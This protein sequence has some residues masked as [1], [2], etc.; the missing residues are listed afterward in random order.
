MAQEIY[1]VLVLF[2][3]HTGLSQINFQYLGQANGLSNVRVN[4]NVSKCPIEADIH[5]LVWLS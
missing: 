4:T 5:K 1:Q 2:V 3:K